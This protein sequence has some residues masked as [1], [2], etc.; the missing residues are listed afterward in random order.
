MHVC[1]ADINPSSWREGDAL[2][3]RLLG[4]VKHVKTPHSPPTR[5]V[6]KQDNSADTQLRMS[7]DDQ[8]KPTASSVVPLSVQDSDIPPVELDQSGVN[9]RREVLTASAAEHLSGSDSVDEVVDSAAGMDAASG[10]HQPVPV[11]TSTC[12]LNISEPTIH[13]ISI[14]F[15]GDFMLCC[16]ATACRNADVVLF[17]NVFARNMAAAGI[18]V[19][20]LLFRCRHFRVSD[21]D[22]NPSSSSSHILILSSNG[23]LDNIVVLVVMFIT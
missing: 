15:P 9:V 17:S 16:D 2:V 6:L 20:P 7:A 4:P 3:R 22:F 10:Q 12:D 14:K 19:T 18:T 11:A 21:A 1:V 8:S 5:D 13:H 23:T